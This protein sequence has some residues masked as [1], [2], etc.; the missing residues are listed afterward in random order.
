MF[1]CAQRDLCLHHVARVLVVR[2]RQPVDMYYSFYKWGV[3]G[4][5]RMRAQHYDGQSFIEWI[6]NNLQVN[7]LVDSRGADRAQTQ[8]HAF[9]E[10]L[11]AADWDAAMRILREADVVVPTERFGECVRRVLHASGMRVSEHRLASLT[12]K[13][14]IPSHRGMRRQLTNRDVCINATVCDSLILSRAVDDE[15]FYAEA[16]KKYQK[17][18][19]LKLIENNS[20][21]FAHG[22]AVQAPGRKPTS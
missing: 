10:R 19:P 4:R 6:P 1:T 11:S 8:A 9:S 13:W 20:I 21:T 7:L 14:E 5:H 2:F 12:S 17:L 16:W 15:A 3:A 22:D 18:P